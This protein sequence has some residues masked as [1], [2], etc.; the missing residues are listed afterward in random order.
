MI[1]SIDPACTKSQMR[2]I[3]LAREITD[4]EQTMIFLLSA[5]CLSE[6]RGYSRRQY[7]EQEN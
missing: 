2:A 4:S 1:F 3:L 6:H 5:A 7:S